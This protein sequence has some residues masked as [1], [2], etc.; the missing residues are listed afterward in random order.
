LRNDAPN[1][2][3]LRDEQQVATPTGHLIAVARQCGLN[4][5]I[6]LSLFYDYRVR[7]SARAAM[8]SAAI[9]V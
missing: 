9:I 3:P 1:R 8:V 6:E 4:D 7:L 2:R 5:I